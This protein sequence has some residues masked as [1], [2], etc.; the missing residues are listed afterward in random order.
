MTLFSTPARAVL[1]LGAVLLASVSATTGARAE[2]AWCIYEDWSLINCG[3]YTQ[4]QCLA[5]ASGA[6]GICVPNPRFAGG[7]P[8]AYGPEVIER[9]IRE[10]KP[11]RARSERR[12]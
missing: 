2:G 12:N 10:T 1:A 8:Y 7:R 9:P 11:R 5:S 4:R 6:G 3:F